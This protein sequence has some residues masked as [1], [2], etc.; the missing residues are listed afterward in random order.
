ASDGY[1]GQL[2]NGTSSTWAIEGAS[3]RIIPSLTSTWKRGF[4]RLASKRKRIYGSSAMPCL[5]GV[6]KRGGFPQY[7]LGLPQA[8]FIAGYL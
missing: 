4:E 6:W 2:R 7:R 5:Q 3:V 8:F 1:K